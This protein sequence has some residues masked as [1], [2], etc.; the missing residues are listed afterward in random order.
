MLVIWSA[1]RGSGAT[2]GSPG[3]PILAAW[4]AKRESKRIIT[5]FKTL[6]Q[7][8]DQARYNSCPVAF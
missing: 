6:E 2:P 5:G 7:N 8:Y 3:G 1:R 4:G